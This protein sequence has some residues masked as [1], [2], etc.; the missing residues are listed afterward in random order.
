VH[1]SDRM[2]ALALV[3]S[4]LV[5]LAACGR[6]GLHHGQPDAAVGVVADKPLADVR[7][8]PDIGADTGGPNDTPA[9]PISE[10]PRPD[11]SCEALPPDAAPEVLA[12][13]D[14]PD[15]GPT[16][17]ATVRTKCSE[18]KHLADQGVLTKQRTSQVTFA[19]DRSWVVLKVQADSPTDAR[20]PDQLLLVA[21][22]SGEVTTISSEGATA[23]ALGPSGGLLLVTPS[24]GNSLAVY[25]KGGLRSLASSS[26]AHLASPDGSRVYVIR[27]CGSS[28]IGTLDVVDV[29]SGRATTLASKVLDQDYWTPEFAVSPSG[30]YFAFVAS[31]PD[32]GDAY[33]VHVADSSGKVYA[34]TS[35]P[36]ATGPWFVSDELLVFSV[37]ER[38]N[39]TPNGSLRAHILGGGDTS[40]LLATGR[41]H[42]YFGYKT[43]PDKQWVLG[44]SQLLRDGS[45]P[46]AGLLYAIRLDGVGEKLL[47]NNLMPFWLYE[48]ALD[49]TAWSGD[50]SRALY[51]SDSGPGAWAV[52]PNGSAPTLLSAGGHF[53]PAPVG[54]HVA[55][56]ESVGDARQSRLRVHALASASDVFSFATDGSL[57]AARFTPDAG[58]LVFVNTSANGTSELRY[59]SPSVPASTV[60]GEWKRTLLDLSFEAGSLMGTY[61]MDPTGCFTV[62]DTDLAPGPGTRLVL[63][64][65]IE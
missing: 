2:R 44:A 48:M 28:T 39:P 51:L 32:A 22:P 63:L 26:C 12:P 38:L 1:N 64:P 59:F 29:A 9:D 30:R 43:S 5:F 8:A 7:V 17:G 3:L 45:A 25:E 34:I 41:T 50:G 27:D 52:E 10:T 24:P 31:N 55:L 13:S 15:L 20:Y 33:V 54:D 61:P 46:H 35:Q 42:G 53:R 14:V 23:E 40:Y 58:G 19:P 37:E 11:A 56:L 62:V 6:A 18:L 16:D 57:A 49:V 21:L 4:L 47:A 36:G 65:D 60:L